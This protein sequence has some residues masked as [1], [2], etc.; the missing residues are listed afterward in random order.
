MTQIKSEVKNHD[1]DFKGE[2]V[3]QKSTLHRISGEDF[4]R[5][6]EILNEAV[7]EMLPEKTKA[8]LIEER[9]K[10]IRH[11]KNKGFSWAQIKNTL[12]AI[13]ENMSESTLRSYYSRSK[14]KAMQGDKKKNNQH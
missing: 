8:R 10:T 14:K 12:A 7:F 5:A 11:L 2:T 1:N 6:E 3:N 9:I 13:G 4:A